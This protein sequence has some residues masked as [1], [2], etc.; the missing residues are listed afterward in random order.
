MTAA[1]MLLKKTKKALLDRK[2]TEHAIKKIGSTYASNLKRAAPDVEKMREAVLGGIFHM[3]STDENP[4]HKYC[5]KGPE[6][7]CK[8]ER[9][10]AKG[11][12]PPKH[13][14]SFKH[15]I[16]PVIYPIILRL[17]DRDLL[18]RCS[19]MKTQNANESFNAAVWRRCPKTEF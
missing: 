19:R 9:A 6:S 15:D 7:W 10:V 14:P 5:P 2:L 18:K 4:Q 3:A 13:Q 16:L 8:Y 17:I 1:L 12:E 11:E